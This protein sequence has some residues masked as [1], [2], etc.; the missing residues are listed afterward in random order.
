MI[1]GVAGGMAEYFDI[2]PVAVRV[3]FVAA[4][5]LLGGFGGPLIY[6]LLWAIVPEEGKEKSIASDALS[7]KPWQ[8]SGHDPAGS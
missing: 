2:D 6:L 1:A 3:G 7:A 5:F 4:T 8:P